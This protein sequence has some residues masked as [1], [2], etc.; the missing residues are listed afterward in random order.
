MVKAVFKNFPFISFSFFSKEIKKEVY[1]SIAKSINVIW[2]GING[3]A[4]FVNIQNTDKLKGVR[5]YVF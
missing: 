5:E 3:K 4:V 2:I 1:A